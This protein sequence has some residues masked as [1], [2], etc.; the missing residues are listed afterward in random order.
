MKTIKRHECVAIKET[1]PDVFSAKYMQALDGIGSPEVIKQ[2]SDGYFI[3]IITWHSV[4]EQA[5][6]VKDEVHLEG[7]RYVCGQCPHLDQ[8][9]DGRKKRFPCK[10]S[11]YSSVDVRQECCEL[12][13]KQLKQGLIEPM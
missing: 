4:E 6:T 2:F 13:Y 12:F 9:Y 7:L 11:V 5:E 8:D 10:Y 3:A 1:D